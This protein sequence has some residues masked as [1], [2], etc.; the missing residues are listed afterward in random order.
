MEIPPRAWA[1]CPG[2]E[3]FPKVQLDSAGLLL[4]LT[5]PEK[6]GTAFAFLGNEHLWDTISMRWHFLGQ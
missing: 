4:G 3:A 1:I 6:V 2:E 5:A